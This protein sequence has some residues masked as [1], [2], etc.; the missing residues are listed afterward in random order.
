MPTHVDVGPSI[1]GSLTRMQLE[2]ANHFSIFAHVYEPIPETVT[3]P[4]QISAATDLL[5]SHVH[6]IRTLDIE[7]YSYSR[8]FASF[9]LNLWLQLGSPSLARSLK[10]FRPKALKILSPAQSSGG[11]MIVAQSDNAQAMLRSLEDLELQNIIFNWGSEAYRGLVQLR[12]GFFRSPVDISISQLAAVL[13]ESPALSVL[14]LSS[15]SITSSPGW[16]SAPITLSHLQVLSLARIDSDGFKLLLP[17]FELPACP[18]QYFGIS[19][20]AFDFSYDEMAPFFAPTTHVAALTLRQATPH[21]S[22][23]RFPPLKALP[24]KQPTPDDPAG[25]PYI[26]GHVIELYN[27]A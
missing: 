5:I 12:L 27:H 17:L 26:K 15:L 8:N 4:D 16:S 7:S 10:V 9:M 2:R 22:T 1:P 13:S 24:R 14:Q 25:S 23:D 18:L 6:R 11:S 3:T 19:A 21:T 20:T